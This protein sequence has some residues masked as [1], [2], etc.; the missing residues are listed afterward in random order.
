MSKREGDDCARVHMPGDSQ[1]PANSA[2][3]SSHQ[4]RGAGTWGSPTCRN[5]SSKRLRNLLT[6]SGPG[7]G[8]RSRTLSTW[9][10]PGGAG[11]GCPPA[12]DG[13][14]RPHPAGPG[15]PGWGGG[16]DGNK[17]QVHSEQAAAAPWA[18]GLCPFPANTV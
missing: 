11:G 5:G 7:W 16:G 10:G 8:G 12:S 3:C 14:G 1:R 4:G 15:W 6:A 9:G 18:P 2:F 17:G 13:A